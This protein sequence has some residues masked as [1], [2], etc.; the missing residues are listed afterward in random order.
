VPE[1]RTL[2]DWQ[3]S[4]WD[5]FAEWS[6]AKLEEITHIVIDHHKKAFIPRSNQNLRIQSPLQTNLENNTQKNTE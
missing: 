1:T 4:A 3:T 5:H 2:D 6:P